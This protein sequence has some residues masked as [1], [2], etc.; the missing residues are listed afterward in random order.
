M[1]DMY[2]FTLDKLCSC[3]VRLLKKGKDKRVQF[4]KYH[5]SESRR[6]GSGPSVY[7]EAVPARAA[8]KLTTR[9]RAKV[10]R[11]PAQLSPGKLVCL[12]VI[13]T[14]PSEQLRMNLSL[15]EFFLEVDMAHLIRYDETLATQMKLHPKLYIPLV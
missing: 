15:G 1:M 12:P 14:H 13:L 5:G 4:N 7:L 8:G 9:H 2:L 11:L 3:F 6:L 10:S